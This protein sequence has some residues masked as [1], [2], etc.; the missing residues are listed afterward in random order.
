MHAVGWRSPP[1]RYASTAPTCSR[2]R[3]PSYASC[4][5]RRWRTSRKTRPRQSTR[6]CALVAS[7][8]RSS[9]PTVGRA[10]RRM[11]V[12]RRCSPRSASTPGT[13]FSP[14][15]RISSRAASSSELRSRWRSPAGRASSCSTSRPRG[16]TSRRN[17][18]CLRRWPACV[19]R[20]GLPPSTSATTSSW[21]VSS[22]TG[23]QSF[24]R[25][26]SSRQEQPRTCSAHRRTRTL[27]GCCARFR[28]LSVPGA[29][30]A[31][32][33]SRRALGSA[34][35]AAVSRP[36]ARS[37]SNGAPWRCQSWSQPIGLGS[38][39]AACWW[40]LVRHTPRGRLRPRRGRILPNPRSPGPPPCC[41]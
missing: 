13:E 12:C 7:S 37:S 16:S 31:W 26:G 36:G 2:C 20:T 6:R 9:P 11:H 41:R 22:P 34:H 30:S 18:R 24:I 29:W 23:S 15:T 10:R 32:R 14:S 17:A 8:R 39:P 28:R 1:D 35:R 19:P 40:K 38:W 27:R 33:E 3:P 25:A 21:S 5:G 4:G